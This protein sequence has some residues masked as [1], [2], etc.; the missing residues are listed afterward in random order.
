MALGA[1]V[2][3]DLRL[4]SK[5]AQDRVR[6]APP[7]AFVARIVM[8]ALLLLYITGGAI[9][10]MG[11]FERAD[12]L[13]NPKLQAKVLL[14]VLLTLNAFVLHKLTFPRLA[15]GRRVARW[16]ASDWIAVAV[17]VAAS[18]FLW[19]FSAFLGIARPWNYTM[20]L[21]DI[22]EIAAGLYIVAQLGVFAVLAMA[23]RS[24]EPGAQGIFDK[25]KRWLA[26]VGNLGQP[27]N[28][29][30]E[31]AS[32]RPSSRRI[33]AARAKQ[34]RVGSANDSDASTALP[35]QAA[36]ATAPGALSSRPALRLVGSESGFEITQRRAR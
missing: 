18:N 28:V 7:N 17:P 23:A 2:A 4:L 29:G 21:R 10:A 26:T 35:E 3:T 6:I 14:V 20:P 34:A 11:A 5:L 15:R 13:T 25:L 12:Y 30:E 19:M 24:S 31:N 1:I 36:P 8:V 22:L 33:A 16:H 9:V 32:R 27:L